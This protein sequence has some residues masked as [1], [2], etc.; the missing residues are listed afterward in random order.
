[1][2]FESIHEY[3][4]NQQKTGRLLGIDWGKRKI[5]I[6]INDTQN[7]ISSPLETLQN[8]INIY[9]KIQNIVQ[10][11]AIYAIV[12]GFP[13]DQNGEW[14]ENC[15]EVYKFAENILNIQSIDII[16]SDERMTT[17]A[18][19]TSSLSSGNFGKQSLIASKTNS[20]G[21]ISQKKSWNTIQKNDKYTKFDEDWKK[22]AMNG[23]DKKI[24]V[25]LN[26]FDY[27]NDDAGA[28]CQ[29]LDDAT[30]LI[31]SLKCD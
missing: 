27:K 6:A 21:R 13:L 9:D 29:I 14:S 12:I 1:M 26:S 10:K 30:T 28:A 20:G 23:L 16:L 2:I 22:N 24:K 11:N 15:N 25:S 4:K 17:R 5:G 7:I 31:M 19:A 18:F 8:D 3:V